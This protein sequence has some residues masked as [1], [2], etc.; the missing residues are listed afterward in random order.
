MDSVRCDQRMY[1][2]SRRQ[3]SLLA[4]Y[5]EARDWARQLAI[6]IK[7]DQVDGVVLHYSVFAFSYRGI[8][9]FAPPLLLALRR[10]GL[11]VVAILHEFAYDWGRRGWRGTLW[12]LTQRI[13]LAPIVR[14]SAALLVTTES[15]DRWLASKLWLPP[16]LTMVAPVFPNLFHRVVG[17]ASMPAA[18]CSVCSATHM[19]TWLPVQFS[20]PSDL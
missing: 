17:R 2:L 1:W 18:R 10:T 14:R 7:V 16:R 6:A 3:S 4:G 13:A 11:P 9:I 8:P 5:K 19:R 12:A 20:I 15:R